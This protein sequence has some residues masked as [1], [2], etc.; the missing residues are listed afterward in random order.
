VTVLFKI[1]ETTYK[2]IIVI[3]QKKKEKEK[4]TPFRLIIHITLSV[5]P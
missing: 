1:V 4:E 5:L 3:I 2:A